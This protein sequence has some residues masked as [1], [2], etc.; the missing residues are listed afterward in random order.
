MDPR[1]VALTR[2]VAVVPVLIGLNVALFAGMVLASLD[3]K[4]LLLPNNFDLL[5]WGA[6]LGPLALAV[7]PWRLLTST[8]THVGAVHLILNMWALLFAGRTAE[9]LLGRPGFA[10]T[11]LLAG[12]GG[13]VAA[14]VSSPGGIVCGASGAVFG[15]FG[16]LLSYLWRQGST[17]PPATTGK[18]K[19]VVLVCVG[20]SFLLGASVTFISQAAHVG[21]FVTGF[22][23]ALPL[24]RPLREGGLRRP[25]LRS[26]AVLAAGL[27]LLT[28]ALPHAADRA[29]GTADWVRGTVLAFRRIEDRLYDRVEGMSASDLMGEPVAELLEEDILPRWREIRSLVEDPAEARSYPPEVVEAKRVVREWVEVR[30]LQLE[31][32]VSSTRR[33]DMALEKRCHGLGSNRD[34]AEA[35]LVR[36]L[37]R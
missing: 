33:A 2:P 31:C 34:R 8:F 30:Q 5:S 26:L 15:L 35:E 7:E 18:L 27:G 1:I 19:L 37:K 16:A 10:V 32:M 24:V 9:R 36:I 6:Q 11:Y 3:V 21:G 17:L 23:V 13:S 25:L 14:A 12:L 20:L 28:V 22:L 29:R 4:T